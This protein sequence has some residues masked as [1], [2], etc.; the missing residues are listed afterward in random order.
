[1]WNPWQTLRDEFPDWEVRFAPLPDGYDGAT[2]HRHRIIWISGTLDRSGRR[3]TLAHELEH[4]RQHHDGPCSL[5]HEEWIEEAAAR[6]LLPLDAL[7]TVLP[8]AHSL[9]EA[10]AEL[11][12]DTGSLHIRIKKLHPSE[13]AALRRAFALRDNEEIA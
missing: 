7:L 3:C 13:R 9:Q 12:V 4:V 11:Q 2:D 1:V 10:A 5:V 6:N 8:W